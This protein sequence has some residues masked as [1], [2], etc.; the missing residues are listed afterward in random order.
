MYSATHMS[1]FGAPPLK[2][3]VWY[4]DCQPGFTSSREEGLFS[5]L[6]NIAP[7]EAVEDEEEATE[8][9]LV[10]KLKRVRGKKAKVG[11][12]TEPAA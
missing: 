10:D 2:C 7:I 11:I 1:T 5:S 8:P 6:S 3:S 4:L 12:A 9:T